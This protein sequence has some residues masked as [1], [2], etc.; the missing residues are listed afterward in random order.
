MQQK[1]FLGIC[2][3][4]R[5]GKDTLARILSLHFASCRVLHFAS[6]IK[7]ISFLDLHE[8]AAFV[9][10]VS[11]EGRQVLQGLGV[12]L[13]D[14]HSDGELVWVNLLRAVASFIPERNIIIGDV[15]MVHE[16]RAIRRW[17][18]VIVKVESDTP[19]TPAADSQ[20]DFHRSEV[21][22][23]AVSPDYS[24]S[25]GTLRQ[26]LLAGDV[27]QIL[28]KVVLPIADVAGWVGDLLAPPRRPA[29]Y[30]SS[31]IMARHKDFAQHFE[32]VAEIL[33]EEGFVP[34]SPVEMED[35]VK[36]YDFLL[37][38]VRSEGM[39]RGCSR[40]V[41]LDLKRIK[42]ADGILCVFKTPSIGVAMEALLGVLQG[43]PV[44]VVCEDM[45]TLFHPWLWAL[46]QGN[47]YHTLPAAIKRL[48]F[49][50]GLG[51]G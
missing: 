41:S 4:R 30:I 21:E 15:R 50:F 32:Q 18:G 51:G 19:P 14:H 17:G 27:V 45:L 49:L 25:S 16:E 35:G 24:I 28:E 2:G 33:R 47:V 26:L 40:L 39:V 36:D 10:Y 13:Y 44:V 5:S 34:I 20:L 22:V 46:T 38:A 12:G 9:P 1:K 11:D 6:P 43:K 31:N 37:D 3:R 29:I 8:A 23:D 48:K 42:E 7:G